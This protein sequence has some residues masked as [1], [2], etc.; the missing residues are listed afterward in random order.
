MRHLIQF[1]QQRVYP[2]SCLGP[3]RGKAIPAE[4][5]HL[6]V[7]LTTVQEAQSGRPHQPV[8]DF[9]WTTT[10][11]YDS[12]WNAAGSTG[13]TTFMGYAEVKRYSK[14]YAA[15]K[16]YASRMDRNLE[17]RQ[18]LY[19]FRARMG[20]GDKLSDSEYEGGKRTIE[21]AIVAEKSLREID[22]Y[23]KGAYTELLSQGN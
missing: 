12:S 1:A 11:V 10:L 22:E 2:A 6:Q 9:E 16:L 14:I 3:N 21:S 23:L 18:Q 7:I 17:I 5:N 13:A 8:P 4:I 20:S 15:Q 19:V